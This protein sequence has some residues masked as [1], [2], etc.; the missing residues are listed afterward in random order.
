MGLINA[1][2]HRD[3]L[4]A[5]YAGTRAMHLLY[6]PEGPENSSFWRLDYWED[7]TR[8][9]RRLIRNPHGSRHAEAGK[10]EIQTPLQYA[11]DAKLLKIKYNMTSSYFEPTEEDDVDFYDTEQSTDPTHIQAI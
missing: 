7:D 8:R 2:K 3:K 9:R 6:K 10:L 1:A 11:T 5:D 4:T